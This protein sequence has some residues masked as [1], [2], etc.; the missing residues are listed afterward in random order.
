MKVILCLTLGLVLL[1]GGGWLCRSKLSASRRQSA[2]ETLRAKYERIVRDYYREDIERAKELGKKEVILPPGIGLPTP[3][4][5]LEELVREVSTFDVV[6]I[7]K[8][9]YLI[10]GYLDYGG[11]LTRPSSGRASVFHIINNRLKSAQKESRLVREIEEK[12]DGDLD[13]LRADAQSRLSRD[14]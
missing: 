2:V 11:K 12:Y 7:P 13:L 9:E 4:L 6:Y 3:D 5:S 10:V 1:I 8:E 14:R